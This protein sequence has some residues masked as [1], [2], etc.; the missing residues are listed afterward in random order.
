MNTTCRPAARWASTR[1][2]LHVPHTKQVGW[3]FGNSMVARSPRNVVRAVTTGSSGTPEPGQRGLDE[4]AEAVGHDLDGDAGRLGTPDEGHEPVV[5]GLLGG[6][7][8]ERRGI[9][10]DEVHLPGHQ[11]PRAHPARVVQRG[12]LLP[13]ARHVGGHDL[14]GH[15]G[16]RDR[17]VV[18]DEDGQRRLAGSQRRDG[19]VDGRHRRSMAG[20]LSGRPRRPARSPGP[21]P[22]Q[23][24]PGHDDHAADD[25]ADADRLGQ[26]HE[27]QDDRQG[28]ASATA[29]R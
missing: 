27:G 4:E 8:Q 21:E 20:R 18:V 29:W 14:V 28:R 9:G 23:G 7:R 3:P 11:P 6:R 5:V 12:R 19:R 10:P 26:E 1:A 17:A 2:R 25:L 24:H 16:Q 13:D 15:V 22:G